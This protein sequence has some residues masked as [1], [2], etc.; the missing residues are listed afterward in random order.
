MRARCRSV[1]PSLRDGAIT[2]KGW[3]KHTHESTAMLGL[4]FVCLCVFVWVCVL[5]C[6]GSSAGC[7]VVLYRMT[8]Q[9]SQRRKRGVR[10]ACS[11]RYGCTGDEYWP[12]IRDESLSSVVRAEAEGGGRQAGAGLARGRREAWSVKRGAW[13]VERREKERKDLDP[14]NQPRNE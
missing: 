10:D 13:S 5:C 2:Q 6:R 9:G 11:R 14:G 3:S 4:A 7:R 12:W 1:A 8:E